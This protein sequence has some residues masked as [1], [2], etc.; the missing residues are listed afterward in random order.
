MVA[1]QGRRTHRGNE[2]PLAI[3]TGSDRKRKS[4]EKMKNQKPIGF[5]LLVV[6]EAI[7]KQLCETMSNWAK[8]VEEGRW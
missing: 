4:K 6:G 7:R 8:R 5:K 3:T 1:L 2:H